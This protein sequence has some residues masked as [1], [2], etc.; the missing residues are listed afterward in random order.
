LRQNCADGLHRCGCKTPVFNGEGTVKCF[1]YVEEHFCHHAVKLDWTAGPETFEHFEEFFK[2]LLLRNGKLKCRA[3]LQP[4]KEW[5]ASIKLLKHVF[6]N[7]WLHLP[8]ITWSS[9]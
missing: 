1:F 2:A 7:A 4:I 3:P 8:K 6:W 9:T 5:S